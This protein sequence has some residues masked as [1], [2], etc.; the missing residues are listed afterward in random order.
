MCVVVD[1]DFITIRT[2]PTLRIHILTATTHL[3][4]SASYSS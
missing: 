4:A 2:L 1:D 3:N